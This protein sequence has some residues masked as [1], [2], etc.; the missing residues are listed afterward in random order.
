MAEKAEARDREKQMTPAASGGVT[1]APVGRVPSPLEEFER[2]FDDFFGRGW[3]RPLRAGHPGW[4]EM[5]APRVDIVDRESELLV[6]AEIP[7]VKREDLDVSVSDN[8]VTIKGTTAREARDDEGDFYRCE[9]ARGAF[10]RT[11][12][13]PADVDAGAARAEF[14]DG[15]LELTLPKTR[16]SRRRRIDIE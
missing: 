13:L 15:V 16:Q 2:M 7:G 5:R 9:I 6:R 11:V 3:L 8:A 14:R 10:S 4:P 12:A 1:S